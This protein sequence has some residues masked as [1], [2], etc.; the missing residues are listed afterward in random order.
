MLWKMVEVQTRRRV[1]FLDITELVRD[2]TVEKE[3][4]GI[5]NVFVPHTTCGIILTEYERNLLEDLENLLEK[6]A[7]E[8]HPYKH[9]DGNAH[10]HLRTALLGSEVTVPVVNGEL[11]LGTWQRI[12]LIESDGPRTR[13]LIIT[14]K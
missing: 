4:S 13:K 10:A 11:L 6:I 9:S 12:V 2:F 3:H 5:V 7:P 1:D 14:L 8:L